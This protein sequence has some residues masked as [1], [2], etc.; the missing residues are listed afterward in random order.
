MDVESNNEHADFMNVELT[1]CFTF[2]DVAETN[3][4][5]GHTESANSAISKAEQGYATLRKF[6]LNPNHSRRLTNED[7]RRITAEM[8]RLR[9]RLDAL[10]A[11]FRL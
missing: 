9:E 3:H 11:A 7:L 1:L 6:I 5:I 4:K 10:Q 2:A 8:Q